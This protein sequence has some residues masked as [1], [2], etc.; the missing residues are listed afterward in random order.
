MA[1]QEEIE[2]LLR[3]IRTIG[4]FEMFKNIDRSEAGINAV[5]R[6]LYESEETVT[7][8]KLSEKLEISTARVAVL[9][10]KMAVK[11][12]IER[13]C[14]P[15][16]GRVVVV[17]LSEYGE[18]T[19]RKNIEDVYARVNEMIDKIGMERMLEF[20]AISREI[21]SLMTNTKFDG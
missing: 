4:P 1:S 12:L 5:L 2:R 7:A 10:K 16:D 13:K 11:G 3:Q 19:A 17:K 20:V 21:H 15:S 6:C 9:L 8:G 14:D 18:E